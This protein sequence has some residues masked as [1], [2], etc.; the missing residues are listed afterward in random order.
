MFTVGQKVACVDDKFPA[1]VYQI[2]KELPVKDKVYTVRAVSLGQTLEHDGKFEPG[3]V[4]I[5][6]QELRN[7]DDPAAKGKLELG[8]RHERFAPLITDEETN[9]AE[10]EELAF[11]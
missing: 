7:P 5:Y 4:V 3:A 8:F 1:W 10:R 6:L 11:L 9:Y 2:Y